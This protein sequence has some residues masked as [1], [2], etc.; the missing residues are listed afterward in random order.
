RKSASP[1]SLSG[2]GALTI[3]GVLYAAGATLNVTGNGGLDAQGRPL[4]TA[5]SE[6]IV[7]DLNISGNGNIRITSAPAS[8]KYSVVDASTRN[9]YRYDSAGDALGFSSLVDATPVGIA[10]TAAGDTLWVIDADKN[11]YVYSAS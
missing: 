11:F 3:T 1:L 10:S 6:Y 2:N 9:I 4:D 8:A 7:G 5:G